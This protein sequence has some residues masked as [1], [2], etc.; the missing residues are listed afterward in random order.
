MMLIF[1]HA[2][3]IINRMDFCR[4][5]S[6]FSEAISFRWIIVLMIYL[7]TNILSL[8]TEATIEHNDF[9]IT[10]STEWLE[11]MVSLRVM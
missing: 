7:A 1:K 10:N 11:K 4:L 9:S 3:F 6:S 8:S 5:N 2:F